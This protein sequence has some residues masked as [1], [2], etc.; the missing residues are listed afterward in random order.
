MHTEVGALH[1]ARV[2]PVRLLALHETVL[3]DEFD[4]EVAGVIFK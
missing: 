2:P 4:P 1:A 3:P